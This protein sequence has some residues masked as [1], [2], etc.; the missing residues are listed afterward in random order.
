MPE[1][2]FCVFL[3]AIILLVIGLFN[4][5]KAMFW[6]K[7]PVTRKKAATF[8]GW[9]TLLSLILFVTALPEDPKTVETS[10]ATET[11]TAPDTAKI[12]APVPAT[13]TK[14]WQPSIS[15]EM[16]L[17]GSD[18]KFPVVIEI[19][20]TS[21]SRNA[22]KTR[23]EKYGPLENEDG[24]LLSFSFT[25]TNPYDKEL[26]FP[27]DATFYL[28]H[29][30]DSAFIENTQRIGACYCNANHYSEILTSSG[31]ALDKMNL[32]RGCSGGIYPCI[33]FGPNESKTFKVRFKDPVRSSVKNIWLHGLG[34]SE[35]VGKKR[36]EDRGWFLDLDQLQLSQETFIRN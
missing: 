12:S 15:M 6:V 20:K 18:Y 35:W 31:I 30:D 23:K 13:F 29:P 34:R 36:K 5:S 9:I 11:T 7:T 33:P 14:N 4:P 25:I 22:F 17:P 27:L 8:Y 28:A 26:A 3:A 19:I 32:E 16:E 21:R 10:M 1:F 2:F 24:L